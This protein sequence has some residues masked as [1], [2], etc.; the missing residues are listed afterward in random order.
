M[1]LVHVV[2]VLAQ[3]IR[4]TA[5]DFAPDLG[6]DVA[7]RRQEAEREQATRYL[8]EKR[9]ELDTHGVRTSVQVVEGAPASG[10]LDVAE[11]SGASLIAMTTHGRGGMTRMFYG[12]VAEDVLRNCTIPVLVKRSRLLRDGR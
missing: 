6:L 3:L 8:E 2:P 11:E 4:E 1:L 9:R 10:I 7:R 12:S 5:T